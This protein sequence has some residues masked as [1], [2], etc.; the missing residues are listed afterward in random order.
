MVKPSCIQG[1]DLPRRSVPHSQST[2]TKVVACPCIC[3]ATVRECPTLATGFS[4]RSVSVFWPWLGPIGLSGASVA[5]SSRSEPC[6]YEQDLAG[7]V[8]DVRLPDALSVRYPGAG[9][10]WIW[11]CVFMSERLSVDPRTGVFRRH[12]THER[13]VQKAVRVAA[14]RAGIDKRATCHVLRHSFATHLLMSGADIRTV[15]EQLGHKDLRT[16][17]IYTHLTGRGASGV[18]SSL[19]QIFPNVS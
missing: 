14:K 19:E 12:H 11:Q 6:V 13:S 18:R 2:K 10:Q 16:T 8:A 3:S 4:D 7:G 9:A 15:Q 17:Q 5:G 1:R